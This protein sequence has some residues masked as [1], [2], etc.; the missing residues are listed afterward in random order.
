M[1]QHIYADNAATTALDKEALHAM[2]PWL[3]EKYGNPSQPYSFSREA[4]KALYA[5]REVIA[6]CIHALPEEIYFTS[7]GTESDNWAIKGLIF[8]QPRKAIITSAFEHHAVLHSCHFME[9]LNFPVVYLPP[10]GEG[11]VTPHILSQRIKTDALLVSVMCVN[12]ELGT[13]QPIKDLCSIAHAHNALFHT[14]AVQAL[15]HMS[16]DVK[17][18][19]VD[20]LSASAHKFNGPRGVGFLYIKQ[21]VKLCPYM[22]GGSQEYSLR[23]GTEN[24]ASIV[25]M[26]IALKNNTLA[27]EEHS[28]HITCV[29]NALL[30]GL[31]AYG[32]AFQR[33]GASPRLP[34]ILSLSFAGQNA[35]AILHRLD[36]MGISV[37]TGSACDSRR[38]EISHVLQAIN[39]PKHLAEGT[40]RISLGKYNT[41]EDAYAIAYALKKILQ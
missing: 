4:K 24:L 25:G 18:L 7:G 6:Q 14:D 41:K 39:L 15:G 29:E 22:D 26:A 17:T 12:N 21:G 38:T 32:I 37:S 31:S 23:A 13:I 5:A 35:E 36:L 30:E 1:K 27:L 8:H 16:I 20:M 2:Q 40:I 19:G 28:A 34:G 9:R 10:T 11:R 33:N 3:L